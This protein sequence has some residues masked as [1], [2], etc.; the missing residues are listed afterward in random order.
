MT[1]KSDLELYRETEGLDLCKLDGV[2]DA[3]IESANLMARHLDKPTTDRL[4][5]EATI[6]RRLVEALQAS[7]E[8]YRDDYDNDPTLE[9]SYTE[10]A[11]E[12]R[13]EFNRTQR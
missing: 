6:G 10:T 11:Q 13:D 5:L 1:F 4:I 2:S 7:L 9:P 8:G 12:A 3:V